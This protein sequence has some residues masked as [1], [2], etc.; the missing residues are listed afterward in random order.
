MKANHNRSADSAVQLFEQPKLWTGW[1]E[2][3]LHASSDNRGLR[4]L[5]HLNIRTSSVQS[6]GAIALFKK[7][8]EARQA[9]SGQVMYEKS[10]GTR[11]FGWVT[12]LAIAKKMFGTKASPTGRDYIDRLS[13][14]FG[15]EDSFFHTE[16]AIIANEVLSDPQYKDVCQILVVFAAYVHYIYLMQ[17]SDY[18]AFA[19]DAFLKDFEWLREKDINL[20]TLLIY[21][22]ACDMPDEM[23]FR[24]LSH[25]P[26]TASNHTLPVSEGTV[27]EQIT[28]DDAPK[29]SDAT[30]YGEMSE[31]RKDSVKI[32][33]NPSTGSNW[34]TNSQETLRSSPTT[35]DPTSWTPSN[36]NEG[37]D[38]S[39]PTET[40]TEPKPELDQLATEPLAKSDP[41]TPPIPQATAHLSTQS[42]DQPVEPPADQL[43]RPEQGDTPPAEPVVVDVVAEIATAP[44]TAPHQPA[45][46][47]S[48]TR[49]PRTTRSA[50]STK[51]IKASAAPQDQSDPSVQSGQ[52]VQADP[53]PVELLSGQAVVP[54]PGLLPLPAAEPDKA[55]KPKRSTARKKAAPP[56]DS[57]WS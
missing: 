5:A 26:I 7:L 50:S 55:S 4:L 12:S 35:V 39:I 27:A 30:D 29:N 25:F 11:A 17:R 32:S 51:A 36:K 13:K 20:A 38:M 48:L 21:K 24:V 2:R 31:Y 33:Q 49:K 45:A 8:Q 34:E 18:Q 10:K 15:V 19:C 46:K 43:A 9:L 3:I 16:S 28:I 41:I 52:P 40:A 37:A 1:L 57:L 14:N 53:P 47:P 23:F 56:E 44:E 54:D 6:E 42:P 22:T